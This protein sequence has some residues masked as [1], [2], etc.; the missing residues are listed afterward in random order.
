MV[1]F[2]GIDRLGRNFAADQTVN[3]GNGLLGFGGEN[4]V[5]EAWDP[6][7]KDRVGTLPTGPALAAWAGGSGALTPSA[8]TA[9][10]F[11]DDG[12]SL[13]VGTA[14]GHVLLYDI[15]SRNPVLVKDHNY[16]EPITSISFHA[17]SP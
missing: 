3:P 15:R 16:D 12:L 11:G 7:T 4:G 1:A 14:S 13:G 8:I 9:L 17:A 5:V 6:R 10:R 2:F